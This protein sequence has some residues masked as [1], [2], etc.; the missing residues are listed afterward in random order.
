MKKKQSKETH[1]SRI[2]AKKGI[3][4]DKTGNYKDEYIYFEWLLNHKPGCYI[5]KIG[6]NYFLKIIRD[7][8]T[9]SRLLSKANI[10][11]E[12]IGVLPISVADFGNPI[13]KIINAFNQ[14]Q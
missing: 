1:I 9:A 13:D 3:W 8:I 14:K 5:P 4:C 7:R 10:P 12:Y 11:K 6:A 2:I